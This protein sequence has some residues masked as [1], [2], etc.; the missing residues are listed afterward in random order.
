M[1]RSR[2]RLPNNRTRIKICCIQSAEEAALAI[3]YGADALGLV[4]AMPSGPGPIPE[5]RIAEIIAT[6]P[7]GISTFLLTSKTKFEDILEQHVRTGASTLQLCSRVDPEVRRAI[8]KVI[9]WV[10]VVQVIHMAGE[11]SV[12]EA[13]EVA[14]TTDAILLDSGR[15]DADIPT[16]GGT[17]KVH[18]WSLSRRIVDNVDVPVF[19][20]GGLNPNNVAEAIRTVQP[21]GVDICTGIRTD[22]HLDESKLAPYVAAIHSTRQ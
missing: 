21:F 14:E 18:D 12:E 7:P 19:L 22:Y 11:A 16:L 2:D 20:A 5:A 13:L 6:V 9:P 17:G 3:R 10:K 1:A 4:S 15:P 8:H